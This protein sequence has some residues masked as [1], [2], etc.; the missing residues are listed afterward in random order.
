MLYVVGEERGGV[1]IKAAN[2]FGLSWEMVIFGE[3]TELKLASG[4]KGGLDFSV[5]AKG[6]AYHSGYTE[7]GRNAIDILGDGLSALKIVG[8][9]SNQ[10]FGNTTINI[11][12]I[13]GGVAAN[14]IAPQALAALFIR[15]AVHHS[16]RVKSLVRGNGGQSIP[17]PGG[18]FLLVCD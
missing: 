1:G 10:E 14:V 17:L 5:A 15:V 6:I 13:E 3:P 12:H 18:H 2:A 4:H 16:E 11:G 7:Q 8:W 9:P